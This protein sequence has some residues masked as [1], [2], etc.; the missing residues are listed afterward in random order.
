MIGIILNNKTPLKVI[1]FCCLLFLKVTSCYA[2]APAKRII[3]LS[4]AISETV[5]ALGYG[6]AMIAT[7]VTSQYP[8]QVKNLPK[9]SKNRNVSLEVLLSFAPDL[10]LAPEKE[11]SANLR[12]QL[13][14]AGIK[15]VTINQN[16]S[17]TGVS[18]FIKQIANAIGDKQKG[19]SLAKLTQEKLVRALEKVKSGK[20]KAKKVL[21][22]YARGVGTM[23][24]AGNG[25]QMAEIIKLAGA[26]NAVKE[27]SDY[28]P[29]STETLI[30]TNPDVILLFDFGLSSLGGTKSLLQLPGVMATNAG[31]NGNIIQVD[32]PLMVNFSVR[33]PE[34]IALLHQKL[35]GL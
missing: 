29:Y 8:A 5:W 9:V 28:K 2:G 3:T 18:D 22:I 1:I 16:Y 12:Y 20:H 21:F 30:K 24:V 33:L 6:N 4:D 23:T 15:L 34:A 7:D 17:T 19:E 14:N 31:K 35:Y 27:F 13:K 25:S 10:V 11:V 26:H 32:G